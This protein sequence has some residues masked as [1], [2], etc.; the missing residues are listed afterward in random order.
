MKHWMLTIAA[1][2]ALAGLG[3]MLADALFADSRSRFTVVRPWVEDGDTFHGA[4]QTIR[5]WGIDAPERGAPPG[6]T[7][8]DF[9]AALLEKGVPLTCWR[10]ETDH[11]GRTVARCETARGEDLAC[12]LVRL[13]VAQDWPRYSRGF[14]ADCAP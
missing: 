1:G 4:G 8:T 12:E 9:L 5:L 11:Y 10:V 6:D 2:A 13:G 7:A 14:Y 3:A